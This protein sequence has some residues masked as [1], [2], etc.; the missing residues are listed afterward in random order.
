MK[1]SCR[2]EWKLRDIITRKK[3]FSSSERKLRDIIARKKFFSPS[4][5]KRRG[6][7]ASNRYIEYW[8]PHQVAV[9]PFF[10]S[11]VSTENYVISTWEVPPSCS[12]HF[13]AERKCARFPNRL[14]V[15]PESWS[16]DVRSYRNSYEKPFYEH[17]QIGVDPQ[18]STASP[19]QPAGWFGH[20]NESDPYCGHRRES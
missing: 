1:K 10:V 20:I 6:I 15:G 11:K 4:Q 13:V 2:S 14:L 18:K 3:V 17:R 9:I 5:R 12:R 8:P 7:I 16:R 19:P